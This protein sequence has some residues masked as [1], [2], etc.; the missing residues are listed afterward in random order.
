ML[1]SRAMARTLKMSLPVIVVVLSLLFPLRGFTDD[2]L[3]EIKI[4]P[5]EGGS[6]TTHVGGE[7]TYQIVDSPMEK[8]EGLKDKGMNKAINKIT[9]PYEGEFQACLNRMQQ[10]SVAMQK[11]ICPNWDPKTSSR[12]DESSDQNPDQN[13]QQMKCPD[14]SRP[15]MT[16]TSIPPECKIPSN[17]EQV[18]KN[19]LAAS[20]ASGAV[21]SYGASALK[22]VLS[23]IKNIPGVP[24]IPIPF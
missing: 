14:G 18:M 10:C 12:G 1:H 22:N 9:N 8:L 21:K 7:K 24:N 2:K 15:N 4:T 6:V 11:S 23:H 3:V 5:K 16:M 13:Q 20:M 19:Y 17:C